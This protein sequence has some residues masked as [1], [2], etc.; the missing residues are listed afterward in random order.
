[1]ES[2][3]RVAPLVFRM[4]ALVLRFR[5]KNGVIVQQCVCLLGF[6]PTML[7]CTFLITCQ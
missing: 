3:V 6:I 1:M 7:V 2:T 5:V 4:L